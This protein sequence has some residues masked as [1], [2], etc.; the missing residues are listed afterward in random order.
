[1]GISERV[2]RLERS[3]GAGLPPITMVLY[4]LVSDKDVPGTPFAVSIPGMQGK[5]FRGEGEDEG[6]FLMRVCKLSA[7]H[8]GWDKKPASQLTDKEAQVVEASKSPVAA[9]K[10]H[11]RDQQ[12]APERRPTP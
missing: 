9:L 5:V 8:H 4:T 6:C 10:W 12:P 1:M 11:Q 7:E 3:K 2:T